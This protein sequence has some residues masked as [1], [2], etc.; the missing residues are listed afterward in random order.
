MAIELSLDR[1]IA[2]INNDSLFPSFFGALKI[3]AARLSSP[4][5]SYAKF[6]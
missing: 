2:K 3:K 4:L 1:K 5:D 6:A